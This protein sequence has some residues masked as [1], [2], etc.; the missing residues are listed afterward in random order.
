MTCGLPC[1]A[2]LALAQ[3]EPEGSL[4]PAA[5]P[6]SPHLRSRIGETVNDVVQPKAPITKK[7]T[8]A[9]EEADRRDLK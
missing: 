7:N 5:I 1:C 4:H 6:L 8:P 2:P 3:E 9:R